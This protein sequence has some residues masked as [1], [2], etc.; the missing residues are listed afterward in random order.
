MFIYKIDQ[1]LWTRELMDRIVC[2]NYSLDRKDV[3]KFVYYFMI[4]FFTVNILNIFY[5]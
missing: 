1:E 3:F 5:H 4:L 2:Y